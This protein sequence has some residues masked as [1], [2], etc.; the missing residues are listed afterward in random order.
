[1]PKTKLLV[2]TR[3]SPLPQNDGAGAY[4][5]DLLRYL[6]EHDVEIEV[7]WVK[8]EGLFVLRGWWFVPRQ[9]SR[10]ADIR[11][12]GSLPVG[13]FRFFWW[14]PLEAMI[15]NAIKTAL[16]K[17]GLWRRKAAVSLP[18]TAGAGLPVA[19]EAEPQ[20]SELPSRLETRYVQ[21]RLREFAPDAVLANYCWMTPVLPAR[22]ETKRLVLT[23]DVASQRLNLKAKLVPSLG[24]FD[25]ASPEGEAKLINQADTVLAISE[26]DAS[27]FRS[28]LPGKKILVTPK[29]ADA[30]PLGT[31]SVPGR[32]LFVGGIN[33]P[34]KEGLA[35]FLAEIWPAIR[36]ANTGATLHV[37]G[38]ISDTLPAP[39]P[40][41]VV[42]RGRVET[43]ELSYAEAAVV[44]IPLLQGTGIKIKL[45]EACGYGKACVTTAVGLQGLPF[46]QTAV[47]EANEA[48]TFAEQVIALLAD[49]DTRGALGRLAADAVK[50]HLSP[51]R[52]Y[53]PVLAELK[54][55]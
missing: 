32:C 34:N 54:A 15:L 8:A 38:G 44:V 9:I 33:P 16:V 23:H 12:I 11:V 26:D 7:T 25:P 47:R 6:S 22:E 31:G 37:V 45:V 55:S 35:W 50:T 13:P 51:D 43:L 53:G 48:S 52:C 29:A 3:H 30:R 49:E 42:A 14:G 27:V 21:R 39:L 1:M 40:P 20:W 41:G 10:V 5:F 36:A 28:M 4:L 2:V 18:G 17:S 24:A 46:F 19:A